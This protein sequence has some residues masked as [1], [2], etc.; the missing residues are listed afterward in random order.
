M[1]QL[2]IRAGLSKVELVDQLIFFG[3]LTRIA[4][5]FI[6][7][8]GH[9]H[10]VRRIIDSLGN[11][12]AVAVRQHHIGAIHVQTDTRYRALQQIIQ[13]RAV[14]IHCIAN[15]EVRFTTGNIVRRAINDRAC[16]DHARQAGIIAETV[17]LHV[18]R[19]AFGG[20]CDPIT[21]SVITARVF[22]VRAIAELIACHQRS[23]D[24]AARIKANLAVKLM[25]IVNVID[26]ERCRVEC[27][28]SAL[29]IHRRTYRTRIL[30]N[31]INGEIA[32]HAIMHCMDNVVQ[33][34]N[35]TTDIIPEDEPQLFCVG[36]KIVNPIL[37]R[38]I[39]TTVRWIPAGLRSFEIRR[40][41]A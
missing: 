41:I 34:L 16:F 2:H 33:A 21:L 23:L 35:Q 15:D 20:F 27:F 19:I 37:N 7:G 4:L 12:Y 24:N 38:P 22:I 28:V 5:S 8:S 10:R 17:D 1:R 13:A 26:T 36:K 11:G 29:A 30:A 9:G 32:L 40:S 14:R 31:A 3:S 39:L 18:Y 6:A 25:R